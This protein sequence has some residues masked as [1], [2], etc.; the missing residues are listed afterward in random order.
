MKVIF[1]PNES[2]GNFGVYAT[3]DYKELVFTIQTHNGQDLSVRMNI[4]EAKRL[5]RRLN[6]LLKKADKEIKAGF[7]NKNEDK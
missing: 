2:D 5:E 3:R 1:Q 7:T 6:E 4:G